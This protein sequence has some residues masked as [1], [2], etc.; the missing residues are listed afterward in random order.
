[1][2]NLLLDICKEFGYKNPPNRSGITLEVLIDGALTGSSM[3]YVRELTGCAKD[4]VTRAT[5]NAFPDKPVKNDSLVKFLLSKKGLRHCPGCSQIKSVDEFYFNSSKSDGSSSLCKECNKQA[6]RDTYASDPAK[7][8]AANS[9]RKR[10]VHELQTPNWANIEKINEIYRRRP[11]GH[12]V[13]HIIPLNGATV[14]GLHVEN[15]LQY[16][17]AE[18]NLS[19]SNKY[20]AII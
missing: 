20:E 15:N 14:S 7:E 5:R 2:K 8:L 9:I 10:R 11:E 4:A 12:H 17:T 3:S 19:K 13:D 6:R 16:L 18:E 1:M